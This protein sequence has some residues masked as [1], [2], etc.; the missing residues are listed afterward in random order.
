MTGPSQRALE[1][2]RQETTQLVATGARAVI[3]TGSH[4]RGDANEHSDLDL[5]VVGE[6]P[7]KRLKRNEE[8]LVSISWMSLEDH[9]AAFEDPEEAG[10]IIPG[11]TSAVILHDPDDLAR[12]LKR[13]AEEWKW[14][15]IDDACDKWVAQQIVELAEEVHTILGNIEQDK[16]AAAAAERSQLAMGLAQALSVHKRIAYE[17]END[18]WELVADAMGGRYGGLQRNA[19]AE[20]PITLRDS[21]GAVMQLFAVAATETQHLLRDEQREVVAHACNLAGYPLIA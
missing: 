5:R 6:G 13:R 7:K 17:S 19:L 2:A 16:P 8:F 12:D 11:W 9:E 4:A 10:S 15:S 3:L 18:L 14:E 21:I 20:E 1:V